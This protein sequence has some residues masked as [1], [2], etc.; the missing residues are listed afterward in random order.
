MKSLDLKDEILM[1]EYQ[2][3]SEEAFQE[4]YKRHSKRIYRFIR[5]RID[6]EVSANEIFQEVFLKIHKSRHLYKSDY[7]VLAWFFTITK[8]VLIDGFR[9]QKR[10][11]LVE[12]VAID[13]IANVQEVSE[14]FDM[15][16]NY[17]GLPAKQSIAIQKRYIED[18]NFEQI[19]QEL[20]TTPANVRKLISRA[21][22]TMRTKMTKGKAK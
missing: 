1:T 8:S 20:E 14:G 4:L 2:N 7:S 18:K 11:P 17:S 15:E 16:W 19:A 12:S 9:K 6:N 3:G 21:V 10:I 5:V 13:D 22:Q